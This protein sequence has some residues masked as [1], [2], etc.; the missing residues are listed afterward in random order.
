MLIKPSLKDTCLLDSSFLIGLIK[1]RDKHHDMCNSFFHNSLNRFVIPSVAYFE[2]Q[3][4]VSRM[5]REQRTKDPLRG[6]FMLIPVE[7]Y[8]VDYAL[9]EK[10]GKLG[11]FNK[12]SP[13]KGADLIFA[14]IAAIEEYILITT[15][16][17]FLKVKDQIN[18]Y[19]IK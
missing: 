5:A 10:A 12:L 14:S 19:L 8:N 16:K 7:K 18:L 4:T 13:L 17:D 9:I 2:F 15:D 3:A 6:I 1:S 11:L